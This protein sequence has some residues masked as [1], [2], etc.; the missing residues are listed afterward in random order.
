MLYET[1]PYEGIYPMGGAVPR[2][3]QPGTADSRSQESRDA[4]SLS[5][6]VGPLPLVAWPS[7]PWGSSLQHEDREAWSGEPA[8]PGVVGGPLPFLPQPCLPFWD[9]ATGP[10]GA[11]APKLTQ[12]PAAWSGH[13]GV[14][15]PGW[16][17]IVLSSVG[18]GPL[19][20]GVPPLL[21]LPIRSLEGQEGTP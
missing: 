8:P 16:S 6:R 18:G 19:P 21:T 7:Q 20:R 5:P 12:A 9:G 4:R 1:L 15:P 3:R 2:I 13:L 14:G 10:G 17:A 11:R